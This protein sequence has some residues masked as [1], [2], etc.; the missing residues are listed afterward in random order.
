MANIRSTGSGTVD[1][2][3]RTQMNPIEP[4]ADRMRLEAPATPVGA[5]VRTTVAEV[6]I[7]RATRE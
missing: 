2:G 4:I 1:Q 5:M 7:D 3:F 6:T